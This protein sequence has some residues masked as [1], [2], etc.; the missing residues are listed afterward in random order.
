MAILL[1][2]TV[3]I[4][5]Y[6]D[7]TLPVKAS[8]ADDYKDKDYA[9]REPDPT[10][11][12]AALHPREAERTGIRQ[13]GVPEVPEGVGR[14]GG[15][16]PGRGGDRHSERRRVRQGDQLVAVRARADERL[17]PPAGEGGRA[18]LRARRG[19]GALRGFLQ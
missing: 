13:R 4:V 1:R 12:A 17:H 2:E 6:G 8:C 18:R 3:G 15:E 11:R 5:P 16:A 14:G 7:S 10:A 9:R 19:P